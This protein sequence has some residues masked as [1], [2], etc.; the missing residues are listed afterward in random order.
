[1]ILICKKYVCSPINSVASATNLCLAP[2]L[3]KHDVTQHATSCPF[4]VKAYTRRV[5]SSQPPTVSLTSVVT[6]L[7]P[8]LHLTIVIYGTNIKHT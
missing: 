4:A 3:N 7:S 1:M 8:E 2:V 5:A 6:K